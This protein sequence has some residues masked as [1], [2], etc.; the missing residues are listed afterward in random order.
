[1]KRIHFSL[2]LGLFFTAVPVCGQAFELQH[3][4]CYSVRQIDPEVVTRVGLVD[5][6]GT[7]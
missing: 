7:A 6:F 3:F 4:Q 5:Q 1:M 2:A